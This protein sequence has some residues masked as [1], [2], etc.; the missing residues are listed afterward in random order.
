MRS[1]RQ[2]EYPHLTQGKV[3]SEFELKGSSFSICFFFGGG[4][5]I[6]LGLHPKHGGSQARGPI[7]AVAAGLLQSHSNAESEQC[8]WPTPHLMATLDP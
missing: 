8:L 3:E 2:E 5:F 6:F 1:L 4:V 7:G